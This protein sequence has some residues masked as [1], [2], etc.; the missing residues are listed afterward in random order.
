MLEPASAQHHGA[1]GRGQ[2]DTLIDGLES[3]A[4]GARRDRQ[5]ASGSHERQ[6][7]AVA[8]EEARDAYE[9][10]GARTG[11]GS[12]GVRGI[13]E[14]RRKLKCLPR[15]SLLAEAARDFDQ[16]RGIQFTTYAYYRVRGAILDGLST[17]SW[18]TRMDYNRGR[19]EQAANDVLKTSAAD[20]DAAGEVEWLGRTSRS[21]SAAYVMTHFCADT[22]GTEVVDHTSPAADAEAADM[23]VLVEKLLAGLTEQE[24]ALI[25]GIYF[26]GLSIKDAGERIG[27]SKAWAS[28]LHARTLESLALQLSG[29]QG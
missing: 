18:F 25:R 4:V 1:T 17:M 23:K 20:D 7:A 29:E 22:A 11:P 19:Y 28:R 26:D 6:R 13:H 10:V 9:R 24:T 16:N 8:A 2:I 14:R 5:R 3:L 21:L 15:K 12:R 27:I